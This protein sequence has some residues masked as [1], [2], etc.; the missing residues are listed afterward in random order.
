MKD[1]IIKIMIIIFI[2]ITV[3]TVPTLNYCANTVQKIGDINGDGLIDSRDTLRLLEHIAASTIEK[4]KIKHPE[5]ILNGESLNCA[6]INGDGF[7]DSRD[8]LRELQYIAATTIPKIAQ[9]HP[10]WKLLME[11]RKTIAV[12]GISFDKTSLTIEKGHMTKLVATITP[13]NATNRILTWNSSD[14]KIATVDGL[15]NVTG[16][17]KGV[18]IITAKSSNN[19]SQ[20]CLV[21]VNEEQKQITPVPTPVQEKKNLTEVSSK[22]DVT[23]VVYNGKAQTPVVT[24]YDGTK[25]LINGT[26]YTVTYTNN[27][28]VGT[29]TITITGKGNYTG[30]I[31]R[32]FNIVKASYNTNNIKFS[33]LTVVYDG[34]KHSILATGV[35]AGVK[36]TY[37]GNGQTNVGTY[38]V[39]A[40]FTGNAS[41]HTV[42][43]DKKAVLKIN[44]KPISKVTIAGI[45]NKAYTGKAISQNIKVKDGNKVLANGKDYSVSYTNNINVGTATITVTGKGNYTGQIKRTFRITK[46]SYNT[47]NIKFKNLTVTYDG[48]QHSI[49]ATGVPAGVK[50]TYLGN[51]QINVGAHIVTARFTGDTNNYNKIADKKA[52]LKINAKPISKVAITGISNKTYTGKA[53]TQNITVK[54]GSKVLTNGKDYTLSY[55]NNINVGA[56]TITII[57]KGNYIGQLRRTFKIAKATYNTKNIK[58]NNLTV[59]YDGKEHSILATGMPTGVKTTYSG[60]GQKKVGTYTVTAKFTVDTKNYNAIPDK[61]ATLKINPKSIIKTTISGIEDKDYTGHSIKQNITIKD[62]NKVL[63]NEKD[64]TIK[65]TNNKYIGTARITITGEGNYA[66][67]VSRTFKIKEVKAESIKLNKSKKS[68]YVGENYQLKADIQPSNTY[69]KN[70]T[71]ESSNSNVAIV[72]SSGLVYGIKAGSANITAKTSNGKIATCKIK[73][74]NPSVP[75]S[76]IVLNTTYIKLKRGESKQL[77]AT[78][79]PENATDKSIFWAP[80]GSSYRLISVDDNGVVKADKGNVGYATVVARSKSTNNVDAYCNVY[81]E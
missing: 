40:K 45:S 62:G 3:L 63:E 29:A 23:S 72:S 57:G 15:G 55:T 81:V 49:L 67:A 17:E 80:Y 1:K 13:L 76:K 19:I 60:N 14:T 41:T 11:S 38:T 6:D 37:L 78:V 20:T 74:K 2:I 32:T 26:D 68:I 66:G 5:W 50:V 64:Y 28:N 21:T 77:T 39:T 65:Y 42:I 52:T 30:Q 58:F 9:K 8:T 51:G 10:E 43:P 69:N 33:N 61:K 54:D 44:A 16:I 36:V 27:V 12:T 56:A 71:W 70:I 25:S 79:Y 75:V 46:G 18:A 47:K 4:I 48:K 59:V 22:L 31:I 34:K 35:P 53:I 7:I 73:V 24:L